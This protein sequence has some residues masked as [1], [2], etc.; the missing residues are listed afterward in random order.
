MSGFSLHAHVLTQRRSITAQ[1][2]GG[3]WVLS[4]GGEQRIAGSLTQALHYARDHLGRLLGEARKDQKWGLVVRVDG[5]FAALY[6]EPDPVGGVQLGGGPPADPN[7]PFLQIYNRWHH[8]DS[9]RSALEN[10]L[11]IVREA[12]RQGRI[13]A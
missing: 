13:A 8:S 11:G 1:P 6:G 12:A 9:P 3:A 4:T 5:V 7:S 2:R 10:A